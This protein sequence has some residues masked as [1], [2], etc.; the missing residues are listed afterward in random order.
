MRI[1]FFEPQLAD[2]EDYHPE[3]DEHSCALSDWVGLLLEGDFEVREVNDACGLAEVFG[4]GGEE[5]QA[6]LKH[7]ILFLI[8]LQLM[9]AIV[10]E[11]QLAIWPLLGR[12][13]LLRA[14]LVIHHR[15]FLAV[16]DNHRCSEPIP[17]LLHPLDRHEQ[18]LRHLH[19]QEGNHEPILED[20]MHELVVLGERGGVDHRVYDEIFELVS[21]LLHDKEL[22]EGDVSVFGHAQQGTSDHAA[23]DVQLRT[24]QE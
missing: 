17:V 13:K 23:A 20:V 4:Q 8:V 5:V 7:F 10:E 21:D 11:I 3:D 1:S 6:S 18:R 16:E 2:Q 24:V 14:V 19:T 22:H 9:V 15:I 12:H